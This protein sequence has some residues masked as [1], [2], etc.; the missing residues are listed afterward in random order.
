MAFTPEQRK[1]QQAKNERAY[2]LFMQVWRSREAEVRRL[3]Y[4]ANISM[5]HIGKHYGVTL[6]VVQ[7]AFR[8]L[9][10]TSRGRGRQGPLHSEYKDGK[11]SRLYRGV[12]EKVECASCHGRANLSIHHLDNDHYNN[13]PENLQV[14]CVSCHLSAHKKAWW[15]AKKAGQFL[16][17]SNGPLGWN[18]S[19]YT[20]PKQP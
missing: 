11:S 19:G 9:G 1:Q 20:R 8:R 3:Y 17:R 15:D 4:D 18:R 10:L 6:A 14:V 12:V 5:A 7:K 2:A 16:P 13:D